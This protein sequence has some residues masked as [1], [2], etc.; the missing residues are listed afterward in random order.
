MPLSRLNSPIES[1]G[2]YICPSEYA[3][4]NM[5]NRLPWYTVLRLRVV[6][7][8]SMVRR[9]AH[10]SVVEIRNLPRRIR[11]QLHEIRSLPLGRIGGIV[12]V[13][14]HPCLSTWKPSRSEYIRQVTAQTPWVSLYDLSLCLHGWEAAIESLR[15]HIQDSGTEHSCTQKS[16]SPNS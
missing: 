4:R 6:A 15:R 10:I 3:H 7:L 12:A 16:D 14:D 9:F 1:S 8:R 5:W 11:I 13:P 2:G